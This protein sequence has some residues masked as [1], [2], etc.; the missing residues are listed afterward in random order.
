MGQFVGGRD[1]ARDLTFS[2]NNHSR[3]FVVFLEQ[4][5]EG[6]VLPP[7]SNYLLGRQREL[8]QLIWLCTT[9]LTFLSLNATLFALNWIE[10][11]DVPF[12]SFL[13]RVVGSNRKSEKRLG[14]LVL[15]LE[16]N[17]AL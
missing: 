11:R 16:K 10:M 8:E 7:A 14:L 17:T 5:S 9:L 13:Q 6:A 4:K 15:G 1:L 3:Y 12:L 2:Q